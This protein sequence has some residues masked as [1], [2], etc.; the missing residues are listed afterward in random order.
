MSNLL[1][2]ILGL[3]VAVASSQTGIPIPEKVPRFIRKFNKGPLINYVAYYFDFFNTPPY[4]FFT[5]LFTNVTKF[6]DFLTPLSP[7]T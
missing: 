3:L 4:L 5:I 2:H 7:A 1:F 6:F